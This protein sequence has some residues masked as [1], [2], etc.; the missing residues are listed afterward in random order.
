MKKD[1]VSH[2]NPI[3]LLVAAAQKVTVLSSAIDMQGF[4]ALTLL[5][6]LGASGD[7]LSG[8]VKIELEVQESDDDST[9][10]AVA[11]DDLIPVGSVVTATNVGTFGLI[12]DP[13]E[14]DQL[15]FIGYR[16]NKRY[17]KINAEFTGTHTNGIPLTLAAMQELPTYGPVEQ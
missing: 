10:T 5:A 4:D 15:Y 12:D 6:F 3:Q 2:Q 1:R 7:T 9:Y 16:G 17:V 8:S 11:D 14:D 13:A